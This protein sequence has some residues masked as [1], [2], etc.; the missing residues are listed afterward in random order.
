MQGEH[1]LEEAGDPGGR[2]P[3]L[4]KEPPRLEGGHGL[5]DKGADLRVGPVHRLLTG[6]KGFPPSPARGTDR[7]ADTPVALVGTARGAG[8]DDAMFASG[9]DVV[10]SAGQG[11]RGPQQPAKGSARTCTFIPC[12]LC[13]P[14]YW[15]RSAAIRSIGSRAPSSSTNAFDDAVRTA[16]ATVGAR[17]ARTSTASVMY[18]YAVVVPMPNPAASWAYGWA[19][20]E[21]G[22]GEQGLST[23]TQAPPAGTELWAALSGL[24]GQEAQGEL[25]TSTPDG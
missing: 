13:F 5:F 15:G 7:A 2:A 8:L 4:A 9:A 1:G 21:M 23:G 3:E 24:G 11:R 18:R 25:D 12:L 20:A 17:A 6:G 19:V 10:D 22:K 14:E 16:S